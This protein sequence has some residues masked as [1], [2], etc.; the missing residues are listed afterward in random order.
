[1]VIGFRHLDFKTLALNNCGFSYSHYK[2]G[3]VKP[4]SKWS[5]EGIV[6]IAHT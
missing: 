2:M 1:M 5:W 3:P 4:Y 6:T